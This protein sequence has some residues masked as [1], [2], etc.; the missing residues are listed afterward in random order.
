MTTH[1]SH[2]NKSD[3]IDRILAVAKTEFA[4]NGYAAASLS[5]IANK[6]GVSKQLMHHYF[7]DR[8][9]LYNAVIENVT[10]SVVHLLYDSAEYELLSPTEA[11][12]KLVSDIFD[13]HIDIQ[14]LQH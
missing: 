5:A 8:N 7:R 11:I 10:R 3:I 9:E 14:S 1:S 2:D 13:L 6:A 12:T 4:N